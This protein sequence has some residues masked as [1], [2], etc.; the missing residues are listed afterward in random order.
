MEKLLYILIGLTLGITISVTAQN[1]T[2]WS[3]SNY[4]STQENNKTAEVQIWCELR[5]Y[6]SEWENYC[7]WNNKYWV[8]TC[9][10]VERFFG[11]QI[12]PTDGGLY[13]CTDYQIP[14]RK[15]NL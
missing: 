7:R 5:S 11:Q 3:P 15:I 8:L 1:F 2:W 6:R 14:K 9:A 4:Q 13:G 10:G 12:E